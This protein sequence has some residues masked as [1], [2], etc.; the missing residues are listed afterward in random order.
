MKNLKEYVKSCLPLTEGPMM[1]GPLLVIVH[2]RLPPA[3]N[4]R[5]KRRKQLHCQPHTTKPDGD[6]LEKFLNDALTGVLW[7][8]DAQICWLLRSKSYTQEMEGS[9]IIFV[10][11]LSNMTN[12]DDILQDIREH[13]TI[14][15]A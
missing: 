14:E 6:N 4:I 1:S 9:T 7:N 12:Y 13:L 2:F 5:F 11:E 8:D 3:K 15:A 10:R